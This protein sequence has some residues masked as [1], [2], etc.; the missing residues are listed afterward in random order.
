MNEQLFKAEFTARQDRRGGWRRH[1]IEW[2]EENNRIQHL[3][4]IYL[5]GNVLAPDV[6]VVL[7][8]RNTALLLKLALA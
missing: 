7:N 1:I 8:D 6:V 4:S 2:L 5:N 3:V